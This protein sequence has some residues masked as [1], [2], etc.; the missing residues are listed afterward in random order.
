MADYKALYRKW[1][2]ATFDDVCGQD[3]ITDI[4][5]YE[6][7]NDK[8][9]H[10]YLFCGSRGTGKTTCAKILAKAVNCLNPENGN[11]C[12]KC[13]ACRSIDSGIS[14][15][16]LELDAASNTGVDNVRNMKDEI[17]FTPSELKYRVYIIDEIHMMSISA[18]NALLK[19][20]EEPPSYVIFILAT[21]EFHK[22]PTT[23]VSR[24][25]RFDFKRI[26]SDVIV[27]RIKTIAE[28]EGIN[29]TDDAA[30][31]IA[32]VSRGG[33]RDAI[34]LMELCAGAH[35]IIDDK[36]VFETV[37]T[38]S[39]ENAYN[40]ISAVSRSDFNTVY[41][42]INDIVIGSGDISVFWQELIDSY[43]DIMMVKTVSNAK[44]YLDLTD[45]ELA[46]I[47]EISKAFSMTKLYH[48][49]SLLTN[50]LGDMQKSVNAKKSVAEIALTKMCDP[51]LSTSSE[52]LALRLEELEKKIS[53]ISLGAVSVN[54]K[55]E[56]G[57]DAITVLPPKKENQIADEPIISEKPQSSRDKAVALYSWDTVKERITKL[58][59]SLAAKFMSA[60]AF[61]LSDGSFLI[62]MNSTFVNT[63][64]S[65]EQ[66]LALLRGV[67]ADEEGLDR[68]SVRIAIE[69]LDPSGNDLIDELDQAFKQL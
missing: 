51:A 48:H 15:D 43:R 36:L 35:K 57:E 50:A 2:P 62:R 26:S 8:L 67:I 13:E 7:Q 32:R 54:L 52:A 56:S 6:V 61:K 16:F 34:S 60:K 24:C 39:R 38:G 30:R 42:I 65:N 12:N 18:F 37:G 59:A 23:I 63:L 21:T 10:A 49:V 46:A 29:I 68:D 44:A 47:T 5:K 28:N 14:T 17:A 1:R 53:M 25:Q 27:S 41:S 33:M 11:P 45:L 64:L 22:L 4:L 3:A 66:D 20:L 9:S 55:T 31:V 19:T 69:P 40:L 58:K